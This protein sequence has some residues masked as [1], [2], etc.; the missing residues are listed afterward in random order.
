MR[1]LIPVVTM[2]ALLIVVSSVAA[3]ADEEGLIG[4]RV[5][6]TT[7]NPTPPGDHQRGARP[8]VVIGELTATSDSTMSLRQSETMDEVTVSLSRVQRLEMSTGSDRGA[9]AA[10]G[11][12]IGLAI[13]GVVGFAAGDDCSQQDFIC[14]SRDDTAM[15]GAAAGL[16]LGLLIGLIAGGG[17]RWEETT[18]PRVSIVP[19]ERSISVGSTIRFGSNRR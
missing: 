13:G 4:K 16:T 19:G 5:R 6:I 18:I 1:S 2:L 14:F 3:Q 7:S 15:G 12:F 17:E 8:M 11:A 10:K 9:S